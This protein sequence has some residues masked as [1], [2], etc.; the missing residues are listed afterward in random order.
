MQCENYTASLSDFCAKTVTQKCHGF[1]LYNYI[2]S[3]IKQELMNTYQLISGVSRLL[4]FHQE[5][6]QPQQ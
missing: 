2:V 1:Q 3:K 5:S 4:S 6:Y